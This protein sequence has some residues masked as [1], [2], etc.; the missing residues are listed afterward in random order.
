MEDIEQLAVRVGRHLRT[1]RATLATAESCTGGLVG[2]WI[3][4]VP[5]SSAY[6]VGGVVAYSNQVKEDLLGVRRQTLEIHGAVSRQTAEEMAAGVRR[7]F[8]S[9]Y[10]LAV[11]GIAGPTGGT[12]QKPVG[13]TFVAVAA[14]ETI[15]VRRFVWAGDRHQNKHSSAR[16]ALELLWEYLKTNP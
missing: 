1:V 16:A 12:A 6:Y 5:G 7:L 8:G 15:F 10:A 2:H 14:P 9:T 11:T 3:T 4:E 13:L